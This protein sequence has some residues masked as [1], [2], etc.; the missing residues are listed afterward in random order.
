MDT[1]HK[2]QDATAG[3]RCPTAHLP[4]RS[5][6][7]PS[8]CTP[9]EFSLSGPFSTVSASIGLTLSRP[10]LVKFD[11]VSLY[12]NHIKERAAF[13]VT[14]LRTTGITG[15]ESRIDHRACFEVPISNEQPSF[16]GLEVNA[17]NDSTE[18]LQSDVAGADWNGSHGW[19]AADASG[20]RWISCEFLRVNRTTTNP[21]YAATV[22]SA[23]NFYWHSLLTPFQ[24]LNFPRKFANSQVGNA[25]GYAQTAL[26][27]VSF[28]GG[29]RTKQLGQ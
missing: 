26:N 1:G 12:S 16:A 23:G 5:L 2:F 7:D 20:C 6:Y 17:R 19:M 28:P 9:W 10:V 15:S 3:V 4:A 11:L 21:K 25:L 29:N 27:L 24:P 14:L 8:S 22:G 13:N 18:T